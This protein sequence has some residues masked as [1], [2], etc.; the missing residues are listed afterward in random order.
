MKELIES[1]LGVSKLEAK[2]KKNGVFTLCFRS[3]FEKI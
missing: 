2:K 3:V 1:E